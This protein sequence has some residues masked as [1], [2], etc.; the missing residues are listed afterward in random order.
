V[1]GSHRAAAWN[2]VLNYVSE[3]R[4]DAVITAMHEALTAWRGYR[5]GVADA[6]GVRR[7]PDGRPY[8]AE[9]EGT[10]GSGDAER[11]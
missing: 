8:L 9:V 1:E 5:D 7:G 10:D 11:G 3:A 6:C 2:V 4:R